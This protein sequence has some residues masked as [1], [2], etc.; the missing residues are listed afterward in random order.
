MLREQFI[1]QV[2]GCQKAIRRFLTALC[3]G[4]SQLADDIAQD[5][6]IKAYV[7]YE[8]LKDKEKFNSWIYQI[9]YNTFISYKRSSKTTVDL[10][11]TTDFSSD[12]LADDKFKY[13]ALYAALEKL[14]EKERI[15]I[16]LFYLEGYSIKE[17]AN[18]TGHSQ[19]AVKQHLSRGRINLKKHMENIK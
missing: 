9:S 7:S 4:D 1:T 16:L 6:F 3:C 11:A 2:N 15:A 14:S 10:S 12:G 18:I 19:E 17:I 8:S 5:A 13:Q